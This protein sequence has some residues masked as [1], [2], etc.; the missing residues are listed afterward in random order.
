M[1]P[2]LTLLT[3]LLLAPLGAL[4]TAETG[5]TVTQPP[6][7]SEP[8]DWVD[9]FIGTQSA[10]WFF[11]TPAAAPFG[12]V[13]LAPDTTGFGGYAGSGHTTGYR[14][15]DTTI[16]GFSHLHDFQLGGILLMPATGPLVTVPGA[17]GQDQTG[18]RSRFA[19]DSE[20][21]APGH[22]RVRLDKYDITVELTATTR[23]G[24]HRYTFPQTGTARVLMDAGH[25]LGEG[26]VFQQHDR[27]NGGLRAA[28]I[29]RVDE[30]TVR[31]C[32]TIA[33]A[34]AESPVDINA[35]IRFNRPF[36]T[37]GA[38]QP[39]LHTAWLFH[40]A[41]RPDLSRQYVRSICERFYGTTPAHGY[42]LGQ[43]EDQGQLGA[44]YVLASI[45][46]FDV[47]GMVRRDAPVAVVPPVF[48][49]MVLTIPRAPFSGAK[50]ED[51]SKVELRQ[52]AAPGQSADDAFVP[53]HTLWESG[54]AI[55]PNP[56][57][58]ASPTAAVA[59]PS[60]SAPPAAVPLEGKLSDLALSLDI[61][62]GIR[63]Q[64]FGDKVLSSGG[65]MFTVLAGG[66]KIHSDAVSVRRKEVVATVQGWTIP[67]N[68]PDG[69]GAG[70]LRFSPGGEPGVISTSLELTNGGPPSTWR[71]LFPLVESVTLDGKPAVDLEFFFPFQEGWLGK[72]E[73]YLSIAY[74]HRA[75][76]PVLAA[77]NPGGTGISVQMRDKDFDVHSLLLR[78]AAPGG[79]AEAAS[80]GGA[81]H[82]SLYGESYHPDK[83]GGATAFPLTATGL[84]QGF[85][86]LEF[87][88][89]AAQTW[90][91][92]TF[93][94]Q[95]YNGKGIFKTPLASYGK[96][97]RATWWKHRPIEPGIRDMFLAVPVHERGGGRGIEKGFWD[98]KR[99]IL[100]DQ[101]ESYAR[102]MGGQPFPELCY[103][104]N[105]GDEVKAG[106][107][108]GRL[109]PHTHGDYEFEPRFGGAA[110]LR[111]EVERVHRAGGRVC[112]YVQG[113]IVWKESKA[114]REHAEDWAWMDK[115]GHRNLD[116][117]GVGEGEWMTGNWNFC[118]QAKGWQEHLRGVAQRVLTESGADALRL[119]SMA[120]MLICH[121]PLHE[122]GKNPLAG[123]L[124]FLATIRKGVEAAGPDKTLWGEFC[125]SD[126]A[127]MYFDGSLAQ[128]SDPKGVLGGKMGA[129]GISP[130]RFVYPEVKCIE[131]GHVPTAF[132]YLS[133]RFLFNGVG[134]T[135]GDVSTEQL[136]ILTRHAVVMRSVGD[137]IGSMDCEPIVATQVQGVLANRF[138]LGDREIYMLWNRSSQDSKGTLLSIP[139]KPGRRF[140]ELLSGQQCQTARKQNSDDVE[141]NLPS[142]EVAV[143]GVFPRIIEPKGD[144]L[145]TCPATCT[146]LAVDHSTGKTIASGAGKLEVPKAAFGADRISIRA[147]KDGDLVQDVLEVSGSEWRRPTAPAA[148][149][150]PKS[151]P[152]DE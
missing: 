89:D 14:F 38:F 124:E 122:H 152:S 138:T 36:K 47:E 65:R 69:L 151:V 87:P 129:Y 125:G 145:F 109:Y 19:K 120:E 27:F 10:R 134:I 90:K 150:I 94:I 50:A 25:L 98:G 110:A 142:G 128:G 78:N 96:W 73:T 6:R 130:F 52:E 77:W 62:N 26:G 46:P 60:K 119:D 70:T 18:W 131:W 43:D 116:W 135:A 54:V 57:P 85:A 75:W 1:K 86:T 71:V 61:G 7:R 83:G 40:F 39:C 8:V 63:L 31:A 72:G 82:K 97:A 17:D 139:G 118:P 147:L 28:M 102:E 68:L 15:S 64:R 24:C 32:C 44:W 141:L 74:G 53:L 23:V 93:V 136:R 81:F 104:W 88:L 149:L 114:G 146:M 132:D 9:P 30:R 12:L 99:W 56:P 113:R 33:P 59:Q 111:A 84:T 115:P 126:A 66:R 148:S 37:H 112:L 108:A 95:T 92:K 22:Y 55:V 42:G 49:R 2:T 21:A 91:S 117:S 51:F 105:R 48:A 137:V 4:Q 3:A 101:V 34:Y 79:K 127:A 35:Q 11:F 13:K 45:G 106:P 16:L 5:S 144:G 103:W 20:Q 100:A 140:V 123:L 67:F 107:F 80:P 121:N 76:L 143:L 133:K 29:E 58:D 41:G